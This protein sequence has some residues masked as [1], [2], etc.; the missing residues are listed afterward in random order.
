MRVLKCLCY[1]VVRVLMVLLSQ[2]YIL[3]G[4]DE[5]VEVCVL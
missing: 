2:F 3:E 4:V 1:E 5:D